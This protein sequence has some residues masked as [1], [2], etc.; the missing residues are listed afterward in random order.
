MKIKIPS[1]VMVVLSCVVFTP[2]HVQAGCDINFNISSDMVISAVPADISAYVAQPKFQFKYTNTITLDGSPVPVSALETLVK[3]VEMKY[4]LIATTES[5]ES[6]SNLS[7]S[8][9]LTGT[10]NDAISIWLKTNT[11]AWR[12]FNVLDISYVFDNGRHVNAN[13]WWCRPDVSA[14]REQTGIM[15]FAGQGTVALLSSWYILRPPLIWNINT[16]PTV[17]WM[18]TPAIDIS[19]QTPVLDFGAAYTG[20][21]TR[22]ELKYTVT[23]NVISG[24][25]DVTYRTA[26]ITGDARVKVL[27]TSQGNAEQIITSM[28]KNDATQITRLVEITSPEGV[29]GEYNG[30]LTIDVNMH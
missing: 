21:P 27:G 14:G 2:F 29:T 3:N 17:M 9:K 4:L 16:S 23:S 18:E 22:K 5:G 10:G 20:I 7:M 8:T 19:V 30:V 11:Q 15:S 13:A 1:N 6:G 12:M 24:V 26:N 25:V 28:T